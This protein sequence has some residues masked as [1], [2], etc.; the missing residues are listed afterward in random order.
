MDR[1]RQQV[2]RQRGLTH[3]KIQENVGASEVKARSWSLAGK[4]ITLIDEVVCSAKDKGRRPL[5]VSHSL[6][7]HEAKLSQLVQGPYEA[8]GSEHCLP[9]YAE[10]DSSVAT[11][12]GSSTTKAKWSGVCT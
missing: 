5:T 2:T 9:N 12:C 8:P 7:S 1:F 3:E 4:V 6:T 11:N 10:Q